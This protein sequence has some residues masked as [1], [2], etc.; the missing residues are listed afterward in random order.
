MSVLIVLPAGAWDGV[1]AGTEA[2]VDKWHVAVGERVDAGQLLATVVLVK[3][4]YEVLAPA[5]GVIEQI[6]V[7]AESTFGPQQALGSIAT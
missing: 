4:S 3:T 2:L 5:A 7:E 1:D 6:L